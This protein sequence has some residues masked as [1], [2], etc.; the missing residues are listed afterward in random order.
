MATQESFD[1][2]VI[3]AALM[4][5]LGHHGDAFPEATVQR[6]PHIVA[7]INDLWASAELDDYLDNLMISDREGRQ[8]FPPEVAGEL[9]RLIRVHGALGYASGGRGRGWA[10]VDDVSIERRALDGDAGEGS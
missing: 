1:I 2:P 4:A 3:R 6:F 9:F 5:K 8:G 7:R 10:I